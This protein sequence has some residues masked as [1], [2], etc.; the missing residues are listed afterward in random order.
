ME[1]VE[2]AKEEKKRKACLTT[3]S[4]IS[5]GKKQSPEGPHVYKV[6]STLTHLIQTPARMPLD[7]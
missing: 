1:P 2:K 5:A 7:I 4:L 6:L 3:F